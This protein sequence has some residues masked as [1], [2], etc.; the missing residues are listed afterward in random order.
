MPRKQVNHRVLNFVRVAEFFFFCVRGIEVEKGAFFVGFF[1]RVQS[2]S[3][4]R[5][6]TLLTPLRFVVA[7]F[8]FVS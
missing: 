8:Y 1:Y 7:Y 3:H 4:L 2:S 5:N 6:P